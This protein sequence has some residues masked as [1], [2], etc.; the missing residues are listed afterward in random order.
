MMLGEEI[1]KITA[2][3]SGQGLAFGDAVPGPVCRS[4]FCRMVRE[5]GNHLVTGEECTTEVGLKWP[6]RDMTAWMMEQ[7]T[8]VA[9][10]KSEGVNWD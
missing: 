1:E 8:W 6:T 5:P 4:A 10:L 3:F 7:W 9:Q 2:P